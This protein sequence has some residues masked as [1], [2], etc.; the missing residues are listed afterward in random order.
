VLHWARLNLSSGPTRTALVKTLKDSVARVDWR[1]LLEEICTEA[2]KTYRQGNPVVFLTPSDHLPT[3]DELF[4]VE[5]LVCRGDTT[6]IFGDGGSC[7]GYLALLCAIGYVT[8]EVLVKLIPHG[9]GAPPGNVLVLDWETNEEDHNRR[10]GGL[11]R[12]LGI[13]EAKVLNRIL[14]KQM[15]VA[16]TEQVSS[17]RS[18]VVQQNITLVIVD[19]LGPASGADSEG[20]NASVTTMTALRSL[21]PNVT[22]LVVAHVSKAMADSKLKARPF[23]SVFNQNLPRATWEVVADSDTEPGAIAKSVGVFN[24]KNNNGLRHPMAFT[25]HFD[26]HENRIAVHSTKLASIPALAS[27]GSQKDQILGY[28]AEVGGPVTAKQIAEA[29][30]LDR[31]S[32]VSPALSKMGKDSKVVLLPGDLWALVA[33]QQA[34]GYPEPGADLGEE[35]QG[36][37]NA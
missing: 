14:Y 31:K 28:M 20:T 5:P 1:P 2:T 16:F 13:D 18:L 3:N 33:H 23:G 24:R 30:G 22:R 27:K 35:F 34:E 29:T 17:L 8:D 37:D 15:D 25:F 10:L 11:L 19:S 7:K 9:H 12:G 21:G 4:L 32:Q 6:V 26:K 36:G